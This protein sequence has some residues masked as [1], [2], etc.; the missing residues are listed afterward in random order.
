MNE[1]REEEGAEALCT[2]I[3]AAASIVSGVG[4]GVIGGIAA[5]TA[6]AIGEVVLPIGLCLWATGITGGAL[7]LLATGRS[8]ERKKEE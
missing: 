7:G 4:I 1:R 3:K 8:G 2:G 6:A 5:I